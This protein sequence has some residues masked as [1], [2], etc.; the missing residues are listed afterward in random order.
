[1]NPHY[2]SECLA[3]IWGIC[4]QAGGDHGEESLVYPKHESSAGAISETCSYTKHT[5]EMN[6]SAIIILEALD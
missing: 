5:T 4:P 3:G 6:I 1:M 2:L